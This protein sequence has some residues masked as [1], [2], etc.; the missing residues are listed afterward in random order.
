MVEITSP[1]NDVNTLV[2]L[3]F[4]PVTLFLFILFILLLYILLFTFSSS[5]LLLFMTKYVTFVQMGS[6]AMQFC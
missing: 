3:R 4:Q 2:I 6:V 1:K 5:V